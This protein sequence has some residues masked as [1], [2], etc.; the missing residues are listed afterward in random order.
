MEKGGL[1]PF[2][3]DV[4]RRLEQKQMLVDLAHASARVIDDVLAMATRPVLV[5][6]TGVKG[7]CRG[8]RNL[9][10][11]HVR[12]IA[13]TGGVIGIRFFD[14][15]V[16]GTDV[17]AIVAATRYTAKIADIQHVALGSDFDGSIRAPFDVT[18][19]PLLTQGLLEA[20]FSEEDITAIMGG[21][22]LRLLLATLP[23]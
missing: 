4:V 10:D 13:A 9:S 23:A 12:K 3:K 1:T 20:G 8:P 2:G 18:G 14:G 5:S 15:A 22:V 17:L 21:N 16:C 7:T 11:E 6:H 19:L